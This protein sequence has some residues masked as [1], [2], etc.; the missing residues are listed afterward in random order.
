MKMLK[1]T[2][3]GNK[4]KVLVNWDNVDYAKN[5][6]NHFGDEYTEIHCGRQVLDVV[7][8]LEEIDDIARQ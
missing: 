1:L 8:S 6:T 7:E 3:I 5:T 2:T 4:R